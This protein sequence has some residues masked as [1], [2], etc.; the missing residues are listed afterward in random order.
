MIT[1]TLRFCYLVACVTRFILSNKRIRQKKRQQVLSDRTRREGMMADESCFITLGTFA[2]VLAQ[3]LQYEWG[4]FL[5]PDALNQWVFLS[6]TAW[7][8]LSVALP[9]SYLWVREGQNHLVIGSPA[10]VKLAVF[11]LR[12][13]TLHQPLLESLCSLR[14]VRLISWAV[15]WFFVVVDGIRPNDGKKAG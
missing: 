10:G 3:C 4:I 9:A 15:L 7:Q 1:D 11:A 8:K 14:C 6:V 2:N 13:W 12:C 5:L